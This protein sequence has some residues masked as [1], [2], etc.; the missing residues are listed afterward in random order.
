MQ[1]KA[2]KLTCHHWGDQLLTK[3]IYS[4]KQRIKHSIWL[5]D[6]VSSSFSF[7]G[8]LSAN[9]C[10]TKSN[11]NHPAPTSNETTDSNKDH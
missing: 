6:I 1:K 9:K 10:G 8:S 3:K 5:G 7:G 2:E 4:E 11:N